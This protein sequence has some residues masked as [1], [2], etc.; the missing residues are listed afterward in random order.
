MSAKNDVELIDLTQAHTQSLTQT[1]SG[2]LHL[3]LTPH[4]QENEPVDPYG[5]LKVYQISLKRLGMRRVYDFSFEMIN[6]IGRINA[7]NVQNDKL[8]L[9]LMFI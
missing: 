1:Q 5:R 3:S 9:N 8:P 6:T 4:S 2:S 7:I